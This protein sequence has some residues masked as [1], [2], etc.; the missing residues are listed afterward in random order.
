ML[1]SESL[2]VNENN[3]VWFMPMK[4][5]NL[6]IQEVKN[7]V[8]L[9]SNPFFGLIDPWR[10]DVAWAIGVDRCCFGFAMT[11]VPLAGMEL[12]SHVKLAM[13]L[14]HGYHCVDMHGF[15]VGLDTIALIG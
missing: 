5:S 6:V 2:V 7:L 15:S 13:W 14:K 10:L 11:K 8:L 3:H 1:C 12:S 4:I 9:V